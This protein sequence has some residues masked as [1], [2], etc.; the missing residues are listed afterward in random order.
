MLILNKLEN[1]TRIGE[2]STPF[3]HWAH[4]LAFPLFLP[5][6]H[7]V[8]RRKEI[9]SLFGNVS[10]CCSAANE[11]YTFSQSGKGWLSFSTLYYLH[12]PPLPFSL[13]REVRFSSWMAGL[14]EV[15]VQLESSCD[16]GFHWWHT[17]LV[18]NEFGPGLGTLSMLKK[19][20]KKLPWTVT[21]MDPE[22]G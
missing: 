13:F 18:K 20:R 12:S 8:H 10:P 3:T 9:K 4:V 19:Q 14:R 21:A 17:P 11:F 22:L 6:K 1:S 2:L 16:T 7:L 5:L 15:L